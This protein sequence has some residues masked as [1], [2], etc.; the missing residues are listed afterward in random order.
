MNII[1]RRE[2]RIEEVNGGT[3]LVSGGLTEPFFVALR[4]PFFVANV[5]YQPFSGFQPITTH[6]R[7]SAAFAMR[8][9]ACKGNTHAPQEER[10]KGQ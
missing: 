6:L 7:T 2:K 5:P 4:E 3:F 9:K 10:V 8:P 1:P